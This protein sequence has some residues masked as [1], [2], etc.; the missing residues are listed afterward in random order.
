MKKGKDKTPGKFITILKLFK[1]NYITLHHMIWGP[2]WKRFIIAVVVTLVILVALMYFTLT[3][4]SQPRFCNTCHNMKPYYAS[5]KTSS[6]KDVTCTACHFPPGFKNNLKGKFTAL[7]MLVNYFTGVYKRSKPRAEI[8]DLSCMRT[9]CHETRTLEGEVKF[10]ENIVFDHGPHLTGLRR[11][12]KLRCTSCHS[13]IVQGSHISVTETACFL[14]HFKRTGETAPNDNCTTCHSAPVSKEGA[15]QTIRYD[16]RLVMEKSIRCLRCHGNMVVGDGVVPKTRC[17]TCHADIE[18]ISKYDD[19]EL[20]HRNHIT[21]HKIEC[22]QCHTEVLHKSVSRTESV[23]PDCNSCHPDFHNV[24]LLLFSGKEG[25]GVPDRPDPMYEAGLNCKACHVHH[26]ESEGFKARGETFIADEYSCETCHGKGYSRILK[27]WKELARTWVTEMSRVLTVAERKILGKRSHKDYEKARKLLEDAR[28]NYKLVKFGK[29]LHN[30][31]YSNRLMQ[32]SYRMAK[33]GLKILGLPGMLPPFEPS[34]ELIPGECSNCHAGF[35]RRPL[36]VYGWWFSHRVHLR[37]QKLTCELCHSHEERHGRLIISKNNCMSCHHREEKGKELECNRCHETQ[38]AI[39]KSEL[40]FSTLKLPNVM[41]KDVGCL[42][43]HRDDSAG[44]K[45]SRPGKSVC[46]NCHETEYEE[47]FDE[48]RATSEELLNR[49]RE[50]V[51]RKKLKR[52]DSAYDVLRM[53][54]IDGSRGIH[55]PELYEA[56]IEEALK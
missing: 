40:R 33:E 38:L 26:R 25:R 21:D 55:N 23:K 54:E 47:M 46:S 19:T 8:S 43:C 34:S 42:D 49:L 17:N 22:T 1:R 31:T 37:E 9:G 48:W 18:K 3:M 4:T 11:G 41:A 14:C 56:L 20:M 16:H 28:Y 35:E 32:A 6:H 2:G 13:Q 50:K 51:K 5:W 45:I 39:Y 10:K 24:Q 36:P 29:A 27:N 12:K 30:I 44:G 52:G 7:S 53:L 15:Q